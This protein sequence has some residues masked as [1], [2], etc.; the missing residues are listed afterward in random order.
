MRIVL[1][2]KSL[3]EEAMLPARLNS[4]V[5]QILKIVAAILRKASTTSKRSSS[6]VTEPWQM[7][8]SRPIRP[9]NQLCQVWSRLTTGQWSCPLAKLKSW[10]R[11]NA[12]K[13]CPRNKLGLKDWSKIRQMQWLRRSNRQQGSARDKVR[14]RLN[15]KRLSNC[16]RKSPHLIEKLNLWT[17]SNLNSTNNF[18]HLTHLKLTVK[19]WKKSKRRKSLMSNR[20]KQRSSHQIRSEIKKSMEDQ[21][22]SCYQT[23]NQLRKS[24]QFGGMSP[25][26]K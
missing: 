24:F 6:S 13:M 4:V 21:A 10:K 14:R 22:L 1:K 11:R 17:N 23:T 16:R 5:F 25:C 12:Q 19:Q 2:G 9:R 26:K 8:I 7:R 3:E 18:R 15:L 20:Q